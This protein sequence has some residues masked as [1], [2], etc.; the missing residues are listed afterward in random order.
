ME[1]FCGDFGRIRLGWNRLRR[2]C[3]GGDSGSRLILGW[4]LQRLRRGVYEDAADIHQ[5]AVLR[6]V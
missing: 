6:V 1:K 5:W 4:L 2:R 3:L